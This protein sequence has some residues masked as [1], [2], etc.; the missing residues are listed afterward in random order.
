[1][2]IYFLIYLVLEARNPRTRLAGVVSSEVS[3][4]LADGSPLAVSSTCLFL[5]VYVSL[6][7][8][9]PD[10]LPGVEN[11]HSS[12][13]PGESH[14]QRSLACPWDH[15]QRSLQSMVL[16]RVR[17][18]KYWS[19]SFHISPSN[20]HPGLISFRKDWL[21]RLAVQGTLK[22]LL[23]HHRCSKASIL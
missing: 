21:H 4:C 14:G 5:S 7:L 16:P 9:C 22:S 15:G 1:M 12:I 3:L 17:W 11:T 13:L 18:P 6:V 20:E 23:Q 8:A 19:F 10:F 2:E